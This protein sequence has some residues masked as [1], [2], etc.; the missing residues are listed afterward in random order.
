MWVFGLSG[1]LDLLTEE[2]ELEKAE[3]GRK[4]SA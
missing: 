4:E 2:D 3:K 1:W